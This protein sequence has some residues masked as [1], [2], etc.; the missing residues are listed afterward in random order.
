L[1]VVRAGG[2]Q[3]GKFDP[4]V[5]LLCLGLALTASGLRA[6]FA[7]LAALAPFGALLSACLLF[8]LA[9]V[10]AASLIPL[11]RAARQGE[12]APPPQGWI[13]RLAPRLLDWVRQSWQ[14]FPLGFLFGL[15][16]DT[17]SE[18][19]LLGLSAAE[20]G[21]GLSLWAVMIFP[22]L[23]AA[24]MALVDTL[25]AVLM[26]GLYRWSFQR[27]RRRFAYNL[28]VTLLSIFAALGIGLLELMGLAAPLSG[29]RV[30]DLAAAVNLHSAW[31][32]TAMILLFAVSWGCA[33]LWSRRTDMAPR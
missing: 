33:L 30:W 24:G 31:I 6:R 9:A 4:V 13:G 26:L 22:A 2:G 25:D 3:R 8:A 15:G 7:G 14:L 12:A 20:A 18:V 29:N 5:A 17:A 32:G 1:P 11:W 23:F 16:F 21:R 28:T 10:N 27:P 19:G